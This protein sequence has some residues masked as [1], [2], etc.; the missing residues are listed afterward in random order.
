MYG[1]VAS[2]TGFRPSF[3]GTS[4]TSRHVTVSRWSMKVKAMPFADAPATLPEK[5][6]NNGFD[7]L[8]MSANMDQDWVYAAERKN[9]RVAMLA[10][11]GMMVQSVVHLPGAMHAE[12][13]PI[14]AIYTMNVE[15]WIQIITAICIV[16]LATFNK[17]F[18]S[19]ENLS[20]DP[21]GLGK[22]GKWVEA[23]I[24]NGRLAMLG[25]IGLISQTL[26]TGK[27]PIS[28]L[29]TLF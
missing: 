25:A 16:E 23:E 3:N 27:D 26:Q 19:G 7:P 11:V 10:F 5:P 13:N 1:F 18:E 29:T 12:A 8:S 22:D 20:W 2:F 9:G 14:K 21:L 15:G 24:Y 4:V 28:Q 17:T 6:G